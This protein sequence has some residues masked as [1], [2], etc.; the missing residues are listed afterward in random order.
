M[1][2]LFLYP[3]SSGVSCGG[4]AAAGAALQAVLTSI[5]DDIGASRGQVT[6]QEHAVMVANHGQ[7]SMFAG[8][9]AGTIMSGVRH[10]FIPDVATQHLE[11]AK[12][13]LVR[14]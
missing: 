13:I 8:A 12:T 6:V 4:V 9:L 1:L 14:G 10:T 7:Q 3:A 2:L 11:Y 5:M